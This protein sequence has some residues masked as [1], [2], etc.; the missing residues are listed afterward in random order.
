MHYHVRPMREDDIAQVLEIDRE[1][2]P[3]QLPYP[4][5]AY[6]RE[7][8]NRLAS[9]IVA[10]KEGAS[11]QPD[12]HGK[13]LLEPVLQ[14]LRGGHTAGGSAE[15][16]ES[17]ECIAGFAGV[18]RMLDEAHLTT[19]AVRKSDQ[20]RGVG[21]ML[22][23]AIFDL[24]MRFKASVVTLEVRVSNETAQSLYRKYSF[25]SAGIRKG[26]YSED[27]EDGLIMTTD[28]ITTRAYQEKL[29]ALREAHARR[30]VELGD[31]VDST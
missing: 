10:V 6:R 23:L 25:Q 19:I 3:T 15:A 30:M 9:Y 21:E 17:K 16:A 11:W 26:Y 14:L 8:D 29:V 12:G 1:A 31:A 7:L 20:R 4:P 24:A 28:V 22:L 27:G 5:H 2:F 18:W 13:S